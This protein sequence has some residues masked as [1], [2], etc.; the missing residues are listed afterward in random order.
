MDNTIWI[1]ILAGQVHFRS[2]LLVI[3]SVKY[4]LSQEVQMT[5]RYSYETKVRISVPITRGSA[6]MSHF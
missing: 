5:K 1:V 6:V 2:L 4:I 3:G